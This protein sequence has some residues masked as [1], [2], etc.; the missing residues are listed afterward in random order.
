LSRFWHASLTFA[1]VSLC[2]FTGGCAKVP[3]ADDVFD[4]ALVAEQVHRLAGGQASDPVL[5]RKRLF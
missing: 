3:R 1:P 5:L 4:Q 2:Y